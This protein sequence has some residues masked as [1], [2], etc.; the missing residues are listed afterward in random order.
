M[1]S[2]TV[3][4]VAASVDM[5]LRLQFELKVAQRVDWLEFLGDAA[6]ASAVTAVSFL[7]VELCLSCAIEVCDA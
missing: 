3:T 1:H 2:S 6:A 7:R 5:S 4:S